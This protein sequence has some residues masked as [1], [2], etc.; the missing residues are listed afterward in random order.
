MTGQN[1]FEAVNRAALARLPDVLQRILPRGR[2]IGA[3]F[4]AGSLAGEC[5]DSLKV[6]LTGDRR[7]AWCDFAAGCRGGDPISLAAAVWQVRQ[8][9][10]ARRLATMM[11]MEAQ[12]HGRR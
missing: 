5:G 3:Q 1:I 11:G 12:H 8:I 2:V 6:A 7:G 4:R 10:A 9:D